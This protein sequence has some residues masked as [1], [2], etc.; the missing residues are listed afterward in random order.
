MDARASV[1]SPEA[2]EV[3]EL[4]SGSLVGGPSQTPQ[5]QGLPVS[6]S[7]HVIALAVIVAVPIFWPSELPPVEG[8]VLVSLSDLA[9]PPPPPLQLGTNKPKAEETKPATIEEPKKVEKP[10]ETPPLIV[11]QEPEIQPEEKVAAADQAGS[12]DGVTIGDPMGM[13]EGIPGGVV[14][15]V[16]GGQLGGVV[17]GQGDIVMNYDRPAQI[18][19]QTKPEYPPEA[20]VKH[21]QGV[22]TVEMVVDMSGRVV[23]ARVIEPIPLLNEAAVRCVYDWV[24]S[25]AMKDGRPVMTVVHG[26]VRFRLF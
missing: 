17:G 5:G 24:F 21:I 13:P 4:F 1:A 19:R 10:R 25:P 20:V 8:G 2:D 11:P 23:K 18:I 7:L 6:L 14:G 16:P 3:R 15:G 22:V 9:P 26:V 12:P